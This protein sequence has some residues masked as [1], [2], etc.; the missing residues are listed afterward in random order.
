MRPADILALAAE[1]GITIALQGDRLR[2]S[3]DERPPDDILGLITD[4]RDELV[5]HLNQQTGPHVPAWY[6]P[7]PPASGSLVARLCAA[8]CTVRTWSNGRGGQAGIEAPA[9]ISADLLREVEARGWRI[10]PGGR[11]D[12]EAMHD[13]WHAGVSIAKIEP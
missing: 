8:G 3:G 13:S 11:A 9:G 1:A 7:K 6:P 12:P 2:L 5:Q 4:H 10:I